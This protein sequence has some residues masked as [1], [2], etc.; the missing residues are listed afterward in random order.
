MSTSAIL[1]LS[2]FGAA[3]QST[4]TLRWYEPPPREGDDEPPLPLL[5]AGLFFV[6]FAAAF[7]VLGFVLLAAAGVAPPLSGLAT[8]LVT[9]VGVVSAYA[10]ATGRLATEKDD[11]VRYMGVV[12]GLVAGCYPVVFLA[13]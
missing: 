9:A 11:A 3:C 2:L 4:V 8:L 1:V 7:V 10:L 12:V 5:E 6:A 13:V